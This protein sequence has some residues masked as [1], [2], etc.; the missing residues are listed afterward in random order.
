VRFRYRWFEVF[1]TKF[2]P[3]HAMMIYAVTT[4]DVNA[5]VQVFT[6]PRVG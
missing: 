2:S 3:L 4:L 1:D 6:P 5:V